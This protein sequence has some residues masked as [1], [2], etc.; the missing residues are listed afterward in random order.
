MIL[1]SIVKTC[2]GYSPKE[3]W[4]RYYDE[5]QSFICL[6]AAMDY[7][8]KTYGKCK[9]SKMYQDKEDGT[10]LHC[11]YIYSFKEVDYD[12]SSPKPVH[13]FEQHWVSFYTKEPIDLSPKKKA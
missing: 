5:Q 11:G 3:R 2:K 13:Y 12:R 10:P 7:L 4:R 8:R 9:R 1:L 6:G